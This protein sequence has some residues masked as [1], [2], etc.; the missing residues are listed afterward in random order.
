ME[1]DKIHVDLARAADAALSSFDRR[2][3]A[4]INRDCRVELKSS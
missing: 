1:G 4:Q 2:F 3:G